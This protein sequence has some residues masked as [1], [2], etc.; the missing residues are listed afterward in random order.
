[1]CLC[2]SDV[3][4]ILMLMAKGEVVPRRRMGCGGIAPQFLTLAL[5]GS[6]LS[7]SRL[8]Y[9]TTRGKSP[10]V[11]IGQKY[12]RTPEPVWTLWSNRP[13]TPVGNRSPAI[14]PEP[15]ATVRSKTGSIRR[16]QLCW[17]RVCPTKVLQRHINPQLHSIPAMLG[18]VHR[19]VMSNTAFA[20]SYE[21]YSIP[22][23]RLLP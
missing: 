10:P 1:M 12:G 11:P 5:D 16:K 15:V 19:N 22:L 18:E 9:F 3:P 13:P 6:K 23:V 8:S 2:F 14:Q 17:V 21:S 7:A 4:L 20:S